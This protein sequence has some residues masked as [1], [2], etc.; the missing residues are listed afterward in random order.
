MRELREVSN[1]RSECV[2][3]LGFVAITRAREYRTRN[4]PILY[5]VFVLPFRERL[6]F[7]KRRLTRQ[8]NK[9][10]QNK[11]IY[12]NTHTILCI[13]CTHLQ[14][15]ILLY[16]REC[17]KFIQIYTIYFIS[18]VIHI[19]FSFSFYTYLYLNGY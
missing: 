3:L 10:K 12:K 14:G 11:K 7:V 6:L 5:A 1:A 18:N 9:T 4:M 16:T 8:N 19:D 13:N 15:M 17:L 2:V